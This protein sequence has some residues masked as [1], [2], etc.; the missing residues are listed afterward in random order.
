MAAFMSVP[1]SSIQTFDSTGV[2]KDSATQVSGP[3]SQVPGPRQNLLRRRDLHLRPDKQNGRTDLLPSR[4]AAKIW[5]LLT[6]INHFLE[7]IS[8]SKFGDSTGSD[9]D[10]CTRLRVSAIAG[11]TLRDG[12]RAEPN[13]GNPVPFSKGSRNAVHGGVDR[14]RR[15]RL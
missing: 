10:G 9:L 8:G 5:P 3:R 14:G 4:S 13:Q 7:F 12:K 11:L 1:K 6:F 2:R 15:L